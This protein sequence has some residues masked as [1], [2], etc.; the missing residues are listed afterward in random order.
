LD[1]KTEY[2]IN[3]NFPKEVFTKFLQENKW[4]K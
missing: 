3:D 1:G 4:I 2:Y